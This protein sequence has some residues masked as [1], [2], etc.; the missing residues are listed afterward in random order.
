MIR[1]TNSL[2]PPSFFKMHDD[3]MP[4]FI[5]GFQK[6]QKYS[7]KVGLMYFGAPTEAI[8]GAQCAHL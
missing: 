2:T 4:A 5:L 6:Y 7:Y 3:H 8:F 1:L